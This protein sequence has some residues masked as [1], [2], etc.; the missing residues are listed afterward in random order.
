MKLVSVS[1]ALVLTAVVPSTTFAQ[2]VR[3]SAATTSGTRDLVWSSAYM[4][5]DIAPDVFCSGLDDRFRTPTTD[6][7]I[8]RIQI[9]VTN[10]PATNVIETC[11]YQMRN[12]AP[13]YPWVLAGYS[14]MFCWHATR[15]SG[16]ADWSVDLDLSAHPVFVPA[17]TTLTC[18]GLLYGTTLAGAQGAQMTCTMTLKA[19]KTGP[20]YRVLRFPYN[21]QA[22][23]PDGRVT[24]SSYTSSSTLPLRVA[25]LHL[26]Q[27]WFGDNTDA[28]L[29]SPCLEWQH[30]GA[31]VQRAC[32]PD[33]VYSS[34]A[35]YDSPLAFLP[36]DWTIPVADRVIA[37]GQQSRTNTDAAFYAI[38][39]VP[40]TIAVD[41]ENV[42]RDYGNL[43]QA[44]LT[45]WATQH[46]ARLL[47]P[48][49]CDWQT[50]CAD[51]TKLARFLALF[52]PAACLP[53]TTCDKKRGVR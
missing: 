45:A 30:A 1:I 32:F 2:H 17:R 22:T 40:S 4:N 11:A 15:F 31:V 49:Y 47:H 38:V 21:D 16:Q 10:A 53:T 33:Q 41:G 25:A 43:D 50:S 23:E 20:R 34:S 28:T 29:T 35:N 14:E 42:V 51:E 12:G 18:G 8:T 36:V 52:P 37:T 39:E 9:A 26:F 48:Y 6:S 7:V 3:A 5:C 19:Y 46:L 24:E 27:S 13:T 44:E